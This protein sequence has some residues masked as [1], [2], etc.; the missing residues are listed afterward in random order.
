[1][2]QERIWTNQVKQ[3]LTNKFIPYKPK[4]PE[5][6]QARI[7]AK[8][9]DPGIKLIACRYGR[10][11]F[12]G[13]RKYG[14]GGYQYD[15]RWQKVAHELIRHYGLRMG[16][17]VLDIGCAKG[18]LVEDLWCN[19]IEAFGVDV[20][21][22]A[23]ANCRPSAVGRLHW[24]TASDLKLFPDKSFD[25]VV[26]FNTLHNLP[27][28]RVV[29]AL[30]EIMRVSKGPAYVQVDSYNTAQEKAQF[31]SWVLTARY[32]DYPD[33]WLKTFEEAGYTGDYGWTLV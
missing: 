4:S 15:G 12:D 30:Q 5:D 1:M 13:D 7:F 22:Y 25:L 11:Y 27:Q 31:E 33:G 19:H 26:S 24:M 32:H 17:R 20:S 16:N 6:I 10:E 23:I 21:T 3:D 14:Y 9:A 2:P 8:Q 18:F 28:R 29:V